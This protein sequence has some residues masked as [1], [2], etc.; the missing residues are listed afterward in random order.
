MKTHQ[1][2]LAFGLPLISGSWFSG[3]S[4]PFAF[5]G[6]SYSKFLVVSLVIVS[7]VGVFSVLFTICFAFYGFAVCC[8]VLFLGRVFNG[9]SVTV[10]WPFITTHEKRKLIKNDRKW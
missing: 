9:F 6:I 7:L 5:R 1:V 8:V 3:T 4:T 2:T 10:L